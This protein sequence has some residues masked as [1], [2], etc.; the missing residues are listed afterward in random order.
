[1]DEVPDWEV[2]AARYASVERSVHSN[3]LY[4]DAYSDGPM[5]LDFFIWIAIARDAGRMV[6]IDTGFNAESGGRRNRVQDCGPIAI[7]QALDLNVAA[8]DDVVITHLHYDHA[9]NLA[10][11]PTAT[12]HL[13]SAEMDYATGPCMCLGQAKAFYDPDDISAVVKALYAARLHYCDHDEEIAPGLSVHQIGGH[14]AGLQAVR[15]KT[16]RGYVVLASDAAHF[17]ANKMLRNPFPAIHDLD[18]ML[19]GFD[20]LDE[21]ATSPEHV[22]PGHDPEVLRIYPSLPNAAG[23]D[24]ACLHLPALAE[25]GLN[26]ER[27]AEE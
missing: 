8:V 13:Q 26:F 4:P 14:T 5:R 2:Y 1:M 25:P 27:A 11:F 7:L 12:F 23:I 24:I 19:A 18:A 3:F 22:V 16:A 20:R 21:L 17:F 6:V 15:I 10:A 9:G